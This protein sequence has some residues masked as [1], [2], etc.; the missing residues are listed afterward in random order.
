MITDQIILKYLEGHASSVEV[1]DIRSWIATSEENR[2]H[3]E[4]MKK[5]FLAAQSLSDYKH[6]DIDDE[7][8]EFSKL[9]DDV[10]TPTIESN[11][12]VET[13]LIPDKVDG[14][15]KSRFIPYSIAAAFA[16]LITSLLYLQNHQSVEEPIEV[17]ETIFVETDQTKEL[18]QLSDQSRIVLNE[19]SSFKYP[20][21]FDNESKRLVHLLEGSASFDVTHNP[22]KKFVVYCDGIG[23]EVLGTVFK[24]SRLRNSQ[25]QIILTSG[26]VKAF[27]LND[28]SNNILLSPGDSIIYRDQ[29][30]NHFLPAI[31]APQI[32]TPIVSAPEVKGSIYRLGDVLDFIKDKYD[33]QLKVERRLGIDKEQKIRLDINNDDLKTIISELE[34]VTPLRSKPGDCDD[35]YIITSTSKK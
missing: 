9:I 31:A 14:P 4:S 10:A 13:E 18:V 29:K 6:I 30:F 1:Q 21:S 19:N 11:S 17:V 32:L 27:E 5:I 26:S 23:I 20:S 28:L 25:V 33:D 12:N 2:S 16:I 35:C 24:V 15:K 7:W 8:N 34:K 22:N 3:F